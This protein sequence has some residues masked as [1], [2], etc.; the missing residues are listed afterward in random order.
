MGLVCRAGELDSG[1]SELGNCLSVI[2]EPGGALGPS[3]GQRLWGGHGELSSAQKPYCDHQQQKSRRAR[4]TITLGDPSTVSHYN[5]I[6]IL[7]PDCL[8]YT[9][10][11]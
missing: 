4:E 5:A 8:E 10:N 3:P 1:K 9:P 2:G 11:P 7:Y 6:N